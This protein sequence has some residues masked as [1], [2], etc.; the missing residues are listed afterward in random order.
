MT[1]RD[2]QKAKRGLALVAM[3]LPA[4]LGS[5]TVEAETPSASALTVQDF[6][7]QS[8]PVCLS[9]PA[10][11]CIDAGWQHTDA[12]SDDHL[13]VHE[14]D[15]VRGAFTEWFDWRRNDLTRYE[16]SL[17]SVGISMLNAVGLERLFASYDA[18]SDGL[19]NRAELL[20]DIIELDDRPLGQ[21]LVDPAAVDRAAVAQRLGALSPVLGGM[22][23]QGSR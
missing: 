1:L 23:G 15:T 9:A 22:L 10:R 3:T 5:L 6:L 13:S 7:D 14:L 20:A 18:N 17:I 4:L 16:R 21:V 2:L 19:I 12:D 11:D 8:V